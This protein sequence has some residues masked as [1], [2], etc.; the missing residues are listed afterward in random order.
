MNSALQFVFQRWNKALG[1]KEGEEEKKGRLSRAIND[2]VSVSCA[3]EG[4]SAEK[5]SLMRDSSCGLQTSRGST[6]RMLCHPRDLE[7]Y[8]VVLGLQ[9]CFQKIPHIKDTADLD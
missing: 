8:K 5:A 9:R 6:E 2:I 4:L 1:G 7:H 3:V